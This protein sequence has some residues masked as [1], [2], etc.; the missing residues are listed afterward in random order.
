MPYVHVVSRSATRS[1][2]QPQGSGIAVTAAKASIRV[3]PIYDHDVRRVAEFLHAN[4]DA[5]PSADDW[6]ASVAMPWAVD[7]PNAGFMLLDEDAVVG[8][9]LAIYSERL[10]EGRLEK[11]C[12][13]G[14]WCVLPEYRF[15]SLRLLK[16]LLAQED[17]HFTDF[18]PSEKVIALNTRLGFRFL[19]T[20]ATLIPNVPWPSWPGRGVISSDPAL[21][22]RTLTG[23]DLRLYRQHA[24]APAAR[25]L[26]LIR[27]DE[28]CYVVFRKNRRARL[29]LIAA[30]LH[31]SNPQLLRRMARPIARRLLIRHGAVATL[32][33]DRVV[34]LRPRLSF[35]PRPPRRRMFRSPYLDAAHID[36][37]YSEL[38]TMKW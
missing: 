31:V 23:R 27:H 3:S 16:A 1:E 6:A 28:W 5:R 30:L 12:N 34:S 33:E 25:H 2:P 21:I 36:Y 24:A 18:S 22:E 32:A 11:F 17:Y 38:V 4:L 15:H 14:A 7:K 19:D 13:L 29:P 26:V 37:F 35:R 20:T 10:V 8:A 9:H